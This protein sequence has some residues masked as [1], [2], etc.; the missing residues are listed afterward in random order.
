MVSAE[1]IVFLP[2]LNQIIV[3]AISIGVIQDIKKYDK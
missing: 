1:K 2:F 3:T